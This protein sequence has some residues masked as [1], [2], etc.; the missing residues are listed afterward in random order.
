MSTNVYTL[1]ISPYYDSIKECYFNVITI[2]REPNGPLREITKK[3]QYN[4][5][6]PFQ[7]NTYSNCTYKNNSCVNI[8][9]HPEN[10]NEI[11][12]VEDI[13]I[14]YTFLLQNN[15]KIDTELTNMISFT[16]S[17][18][19]LSLSSNYIPKKILSFITFI[20]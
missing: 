17:K 16:Q 8:I 19:N 18:T 1:Y 4:S 9:Y 13:S 3:K 5:L 20:E 2:D 12:H 11:L 15:Y 10:K 7:S 14:L 6:S